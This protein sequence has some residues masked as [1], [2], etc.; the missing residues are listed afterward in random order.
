MGVLWPLR[1]VCL[2]WVTTGTHF[3]QQSLCCLHSKYTVIHN[4]FAVPLTVLCRVLFNCVCT[5]DIKTRDRQCI[6]LMPTRCLHLKLR[7]CT[8]L[9]LRNE[10]RKLLLCRMKSLCHEC[11]RCT[12]R[13]IF[14]KNCS[15]VSLVEQGKKREKPVS[16]F[17]SL[18]NQLEASSESIS[19][20]RTCRSLV[21]LCGSCGFSLW[22]CHPFKV[23]LV[24][25]VS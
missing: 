21:Q 20:L 17:I 1:T 22:P 25:I 12:F 3:R 16:V 13:N 9:Q 19:N 10:K 11:T 15:N 8:E 18:L 7:L 4:V 5:L 23:L 2:P 24:G 6:P 14:F